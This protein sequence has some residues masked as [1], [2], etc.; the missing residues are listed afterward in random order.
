M[1]EVI[2]RLDWQ[3]VLIIE[4]LLWIFFIGGMSFVGV[5]IWRLFKDWARG[6]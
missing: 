3:A 2:A 4:F 6:K 5:I 1:N